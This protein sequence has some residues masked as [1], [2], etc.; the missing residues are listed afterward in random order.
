MS[1]SV[2]HGDEIV[3]WK[4]GPVSLVAPKQPPHQP[5]QSATRC[6]LA[7]LTSKPLAWGAARGGESNHRYSSHRDWGW[8]LSPCSFKGA[9]RVR[10]L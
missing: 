10:R 9:L 4:P 8:R 5:N 3:V 6:W 7:Y 1:N 2:E